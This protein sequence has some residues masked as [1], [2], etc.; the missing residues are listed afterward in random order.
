MTN[1]TTSTGRTEAFVQQM[2]DQMN[3]LARTLIP[4]CVS[5]YHIM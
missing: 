3:Q 5:V 4:T 2:T 1:R